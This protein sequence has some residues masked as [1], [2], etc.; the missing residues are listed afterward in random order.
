MQ[1]KKNFR[2]ISI[3]LMNQLGLY[4]N[5][6][7]L[8]YLSMY[9]VKIN[10]IRA[11]LSIKSKYVGAAPEDNRTILLPLI[12]TSHYKCIQLLLL[13]KALEF[14]GAKIKVLVCG[15][16]LEICEIR[17][18]A[19]EGNPDPCWKCRFN[20]RNIVPLFGMDVISVK[21][22]TIDLDY[23][24]EELKEKNTDKR[25]DIN[26][27]R[28]IEDSVVRHYYGA[29]PDDA[30]DVNR[31]REKHIRTARISLY[32]AQR[33]NEKI[34]P[35]IILGYMAAYSAWEPYKLY[36]ESEG[37]PFRLVSSTQFNERSQIF[38]W[39]ELYTSRRRFDMYCGNRPVHFLTKAE[40]YAL[41]NFIATRKDGLDPVLNKLGIAQNKSL[42]IEKYGIIISKEKTNICLFPN[43]VWDTGM[44]SLKSIFDTIEEW[45]LSTV[46]IAIENDNFHLYIRCHPAEVLA[47]K[48]SGMGIEYVVRKKFPCLPPNVTIIS[49]EN[50]I[51]SYELYSAMDIGVVTN[52][53]IGLEM[54]LDKLAVIVVGS[55]PYSFVENINAPDSVG[56]YIKLITGK[57]ELKMPDENLVKLFAYFY[58]IKSPIPWYLTSKS[59]PGELLESFPFGSIDYL[60]PGVERLTDHLCSCVLNSETSPE[61]W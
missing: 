31:V 61:S 35:D 53:T 19:M 36:F 55:A 2:K 30:D 7:K 37:I 25:Y 13:A 22:V 48:N 15:Q 12:E 52:G 43:V 17:S 49:S 29:V 58:F 42:N 9:A 8:I 23:T 54:M 14:R 50:R 3:F 51:S 5:V 57:S 16:A 4:H 27:S 38:N 20:E 45:V 1:L 21:D 32:A 60:R 39:T 41:K 40:N 18:K 26:F 33:I 28:C 44:S 59:Y 24:K 47:D 56:D 6:K 11:Q 10:K 34:K 46:K